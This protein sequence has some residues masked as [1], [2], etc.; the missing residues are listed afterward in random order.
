MQN[1]DHHGDCSDGCTSMRPAHMIFRTYIIVL[2]CLAFQACREHSVEPEG[3]VTL[4]STSFESSGVPTTEGWVIPDTSL[5]TLQHDAPTGG[6]EWSLGLEAGWYPQQGLARRFVSGLS[7]RNIVRL[8]V[9]SKG[10]FFRDISLGSW[11]DRRFKTLPC[12]SSVWTQL[13]ILDTLTLRPEDSL[14]VTLNAGS[15]EVAFGRG[16]FDLVS[17]EKLP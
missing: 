1:N 9:N 7:G 16:L 17:L 15:T 8:R 5:A 3:T 6:G 12:T 11:T 13:E 10:S 14:V 4:F 2:G